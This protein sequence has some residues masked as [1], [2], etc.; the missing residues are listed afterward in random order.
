MN[1]KEIIELVFDYLPETIKNCDL[2]INLKKTLLNPSDYA[3][4]VGKVLVCES[5][6]QDI[7][8]D[9]PNLED[10]LAVTKMGQLI[11]MAYYE[12]EIACEQKVATVDIFSDGIDFNVI[13]CYTLNGKECT[14]TLECFDGIKTIRT[15]MERKEKGICE[16][17]YAEVACYDEDG[18]LLPFDYEKLLDV[19]FSQRF[20]VSLEIARFLRTNFQTFKDKINRYHIKEQTKEY[21]EMLDIELLSFVGPFEVG[22]FK[23]SYF[24]YLNQDL[25]QSLLSAGD[26]DPEDAFYYH[27][28]REDLIDKIGNNL[29]QQM[30]ASEIVISSN[31]T[32]VLFAVVTDYMPDVVYTKGIIIKKEKDSYIFYYAHLENDKVI[33][34]PQELSTEQVQDLYFKGNS[35]DSL[36]LK[37]FF[38]VKRER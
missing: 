37:E 8:Q 13:V 18:N 22:N 23:D 14:T 30:G 15:I 21:D 29:K 4:M 28:S 10:K 31:I 32:D 16:E 26:E 35:Q 11:R 2:F 6:Y 3:L 19:E 27:Y 25:Y 7:I 33:L 20:S 17:Y 36:A 9:Y 12:Q 1:T 5:L 38:G 24:D 34:M